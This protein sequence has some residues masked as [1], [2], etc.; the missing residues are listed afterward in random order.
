MAKDF[1]LMENSNSSNNASIH[2]VS[3]PSRRVV[4]QG[5]LG[6]ALTGFLA[7]LAGLSVSGCATG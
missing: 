2:E 7:P 6:V 4:L 1:D 3:E 5:G